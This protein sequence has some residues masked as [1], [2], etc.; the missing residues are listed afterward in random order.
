MRAEEQCYPVANFSLTVGLHEAWHVLYFS[1]VPFVR[2]RKSLSTL[3]SLD[4]TQLTMGNNNKTTDRTR[5]I[6]KTF[7]LKRSRKTGK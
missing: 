7:T 4:K 1:S 2:G 3:G 6:R 5:E